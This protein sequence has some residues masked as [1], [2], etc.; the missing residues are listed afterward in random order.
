MDKNRYREAVDL[1]QSQPTEGF[2]LSPAELRIRMH[3]LMQRTLLRRRIQIA[4]SLGWGV[5]A[6]GSLMFFDESPARWFRVLEIVSIL[7]LIIQVPVVPDA[8]SKLR[9]RLLTLRTFPRSES[10]VDY[11]NRQLSAER[12]FWRRIKFVAPALSLAGLALIL[13]SGKVLAQALGG[14]IILLAV[15]WLL[16][17]R[18]TLPGLQ[19]EM[20]EVDHYRRTVDS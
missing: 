8:A 16:Y 2:R 7:I 11:Y 1:W 6:I 19:R 12:E 9:H 15:I 13:F 4:A 3:R 20:E 14:A 17:G 18:K 5:G 10:C